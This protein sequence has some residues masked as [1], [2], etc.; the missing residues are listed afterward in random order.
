MPS[1]IKHALDIGAFSTAIAS[2]FDLLPRATS[3]LAFIWLA[4][5]I[6]ESRT[7]QR[8]LKPSKIPK[9]RKEDEP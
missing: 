7:V 5:R 1:E 9:T 4:L 3:L 2:L 6:Y 8:W